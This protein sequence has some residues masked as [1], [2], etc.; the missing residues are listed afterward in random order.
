MSHDVQREAILNRGITTT[1]Q[2]AGR[3][4]P[5]AAPN[6]VR[7]TP[8][9]AVYEPPLPGATPA[10]ADNSPLDASQYLKKSANGNIIAEVTDL[11]FASEDDSMRPAFEGKTVEMIGQFMPVKGATDW[12]GSRSC[13]CSWCVARRTRGPWR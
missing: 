10:P 3:N 6:A 2:P 7:Q 5:S 1:L 8:A 11:L 4:R 9:S 12:H 13:G